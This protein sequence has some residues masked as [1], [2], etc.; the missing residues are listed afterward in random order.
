MQPNLSL[1]PP[2]SASRFHRTDLRATAAN[3]DGFAGMQLES[4]FIEVSNRFAEKTRWAD[5]ISFCRWHITDNNHLD[6]VG[7]VTAYTTMGNAY[8]ALNDL[9]GSEKCYRVALAAC[10]KGASAMTAAEIAQC[11]K[12]FLG[13]ARVLKMQNRTAEA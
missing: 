13:Y 8:R 11:K 7:F 2:G 9:A 12:Q 3:T 10:D 4:A 6:T 5:V 1:L